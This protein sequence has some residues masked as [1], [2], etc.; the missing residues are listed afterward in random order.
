M[1][2]W[3]VAGFILSVIIVPI[4]IYSFGRVMFSKLIFHNEQDDM[5]SRDGILLVLLVGGM[6]AWA[7]MMGWGDAGAVSLVVF[8]LVLIGACI[9]L[10]LASSCVSA[11]LARRRKREEHDGVDE[12]DQASS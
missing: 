7:G 10:S 4:F 2:G 12:S 8:F 9:A 1:G 11:L 3:A 6:F 5:T